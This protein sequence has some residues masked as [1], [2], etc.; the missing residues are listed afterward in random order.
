MVEPALAR[1]KQFCIQNKK[2]IIICSLLFLSFFTLYFVS[3]FL[4]SETR[5][6]N[7]IDTLFQSDCPEVIK[8][9]SQSAVI[10]RVEIHPLYKLIVYP[11]AWLLSQVIASKVVV[12]VIINAFFGALGVVLSYLFFWLLSKNYLNSALLSLLFGVSMSKLLFSIVPD[13]PSLIICSLLTVYILFLLSLSQKRLF[14]LAWVL[15]GIFSFGVSIINITQTFIFF[16]VL[17]VML[18]REKTITF[19]HWLAI[20]R[21]IIALL[22]PLAILAITLDIV[23]HHHVH[24]FSLRVLSDNFRRFG[25]FLIFQDPLLVITTLLKHFFVVNVVAPVP[26]LFVMS[27]RTLPGVTFT[28]SWKYSVIG[29]TGLLLWLI[30][31]IGGI[32]KSLSSRQKYLPLF[33]GASLCLIFYLVFHSFYGVVQGVAERGGIEYFEYTGNFTFLVF[34]FLSPYS[35]SSKPVLRVSL[36]SL[37]LLVGFNNLMVAKYLI[38]LYT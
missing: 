16:M 15:A 13:F 30:L 27:D 24:L 36:L 12:A 8:T 23:L 10:H 32:A 26:D 14:L 1:F 3:G 20:V 4:L 9:I 2:S 6:F 18:T 17:M 21:L 35:L 25:G 22:F 11:L 19:S 33:F 34:M 31:L 28:T 7:E 38:D 37:V 29:W 5:A